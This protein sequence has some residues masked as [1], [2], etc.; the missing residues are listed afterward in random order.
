MHKMKW[1]HFYQIVLDCIPKKKAFTNTPRIGQN[2]SGP[3]FFIPSD[4]LFL[5]QIPCQYFLYS[6]TNGDQTTHSLGGRGK[7]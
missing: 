6:F 1:G 5:V 3:F 4:E 7:L 2:G